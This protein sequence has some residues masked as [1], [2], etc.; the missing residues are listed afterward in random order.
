FFT[1]TDEVQQFALAAQVVTAL[2]AHPD[3][4]L[5]F[6]DPIANARR[7]VVE[8]ARN[9]SIGGKTA[10]TSHDRIA[11]R[12]VDFRM[13]RRAG[14]ASRNAGDGGRGC[15]CLR[16]GAEAKRDEQREGEDS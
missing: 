13:A 14:L 4:A 16:K 2:V 6:I 5:V 10:G 7:L 9:Q 8:F 3:M 11:I 1:G 12:V 15:A